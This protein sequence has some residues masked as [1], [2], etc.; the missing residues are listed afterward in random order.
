L[1]FLPTPKAPVVLDKGISQGAELAVGILVFFG[2]GALIDWWLGTRPVFMIALT[3]FAMIGYFVR[4]YYAYNSAMSK[5]EQERFDKSRG[6]R[7]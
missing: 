3:I 2:I 4:T 6:D 7:V 1:K 5:I